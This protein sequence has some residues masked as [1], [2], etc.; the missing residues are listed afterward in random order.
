MTILKA[1]IIIILGFGGGVVISGAVFAFIA[2]IG[3]VPRLAQ[4][5]HTEKLISLYEEAIIAGGIWGTSTL[6]I[7]YY[8]PLPK[9]FIIIFCLL[10]G[11][12]YGCLAVSLAEVLNVI[13]ILTRRGG[14]KK[15]LTYFILALA[16][17]KLLGS[18]LYYFIPGFYNV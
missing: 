4:K 2:I 14:L 12:F 16:L 1:L 3:V 8:L 6:L 10:I 11:I 18:V 13:P 7:N 17:G 15:G 5:T 9:I